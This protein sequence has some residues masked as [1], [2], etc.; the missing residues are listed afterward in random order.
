MSSL[1]RNFLPP[2][3]TPE[4]RAIINSFLKEEW[5]EA[6][7]SWKPVSNNVAKALDMIRNKKQKLSP[8]N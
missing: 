5:D 1:L 2:Y 8:D 4:K 6:T 7:L 3:D